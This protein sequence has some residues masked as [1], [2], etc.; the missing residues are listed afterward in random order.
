[1]LPSCSKY[2]RILTT[3]DELTLTRHFPS[4]K[5]DQHYP[6]GMVLGCWLGGVDSRADS[7][8]GSSLNFTLLGSKMH[9]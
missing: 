2:A 6:L 5:G 8:Q 4:L 3:S 7:P 9:P 1:M